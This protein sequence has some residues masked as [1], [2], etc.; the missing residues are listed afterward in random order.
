[1]LA[2]L[3]I[4]LVFLYLAIS[5]ALFFAQTS[6]LFPARLVPPAGPLPPEAERIEFT[7]RDGVRL[8]GV[9]LPPAGRAAS[10]TLI[11]GFAGNASNAQ[12]IA[13]FL[14]ELY[15]DRP[16]IAFHYRGYRPSGGVPGA[17][18]LLA[19]VPLLY[20]FA[21]D[22]VKPERIVAVGISLGS[23]VAA[24]LSAQRPLDGLILVTPFDS[25]RA[26]AGGKFPWLPVSLLMR[27]DLPSDAFLRASGTPTAIVAAEHDEVIPRRHTDAL[28]RIVPKLVFDATIPGAR[29]NDIA[30]HPA[31]KQAMR[32]GLER[33]EAAGVAGQPDG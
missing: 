6:I 21:R 4:G 2:K 16:V 13:E 32:K 24:G 22:R 29:H 7:A 17:E 14:H 26:V 23:G 10:R 31:F 18:A 8:E 25:L 1:M 15:P 20:D 33:I 27:H 5:A 30:F 11:L 9:L 28:R 3:L 19:D 12:G